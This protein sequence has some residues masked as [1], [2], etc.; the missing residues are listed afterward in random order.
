MVTGMS[1]RHWVANWQ[2]APSGYR[3][4]GISPSLFGGFFAIAL[5]CDR[6]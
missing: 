1:F 5:K 3:N 6:R 2:D 4:S